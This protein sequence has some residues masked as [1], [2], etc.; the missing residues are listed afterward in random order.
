M[1]E[2]QHEARQPEW[3]CQDCGAAWP[4]EPARGRLRAE[5]AG[6]TALAVLMWCYLEGFFHDALDGTDGAFERFVGW[7]RPGSA[8]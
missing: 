6:G 1:G 8:R 3:T 2:P 5:T 7:T 4:C